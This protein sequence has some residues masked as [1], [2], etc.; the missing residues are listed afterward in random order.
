YEQLHSR[1][2]RIL[3]AYFQPAASLGLSLT[4]GLDTR[5][6][7]AGRP[8]SVKP[9]ACYTYAGIYRQCFDVQVAAKIA[10]ACG[11]SHS[12]IEIDDAFLRVL[13]GFGKETVWRTGGCQAFLGPHELYCSRRAGSLAPIRLTGN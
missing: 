8:L 2:S 3:P 5:M 9:A 1:M 13:G 7:L 4:G 12:A 11:E 10:A 6:V